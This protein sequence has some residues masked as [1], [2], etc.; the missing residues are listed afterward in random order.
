MILHSE[1]HRS[2]QIL[3]FITYPILQSS[4]F[5]GNVC[6]LNLAFRRLTL[7]VI[8]SN[9]LFDGRCAQY[10]EIKVMWIITSGVYSYS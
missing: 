1:D 4:K 6:T 3:K 7:S 5:Y 9:D 2:L 10:R 8:F